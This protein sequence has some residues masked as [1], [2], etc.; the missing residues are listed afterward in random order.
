MKQA[1]LVAKVFAAISVMGLSAWVAVKLYM[2][3]YH[4]SLVPSCLNV[5]RV[6]YVRES[7]WGI[8]PG[9]NETGV[10]VFGLPEDFVVTVKT[11]RIGFLRQAC[12]KSAM[13]RKTGGR[14][15]EWKATPMVAE[16]QWLV[17]ESTSRGASASGSPRI[18]NF[19]DQ[20]GFGIS[21]DEEIQEMSDKALSEP[22]NYYHSG[23]TSLLIVIPDKRRVVYAYAG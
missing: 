8:G 2:H 17:R 16:I 7:L 18:A 20:Y 5:S 14:F 13:S 12:S 19:L 11:G 23:R 21:I 1:A 22:G 15:T 6:L 10:L 3:R 9:G 4:L